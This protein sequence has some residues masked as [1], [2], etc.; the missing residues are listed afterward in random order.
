[1]VPALSSLT[2]LLA[3]LDRKARVLLSAGLI[4]VVAAA[5]S[6]GHLL[7]RN[8]NAPTLVSLNLKSGSREVALN[9]P[10]VF[11]FSRP[12]AES[13]VQAG[14]RI[15]P[16]AN[17]D[18]HQTGPVVYTWK[19]SDPW[20]DLTSYTVSMRAGEDESGHQITSRTWRFT[21]TIVPRVTGLLTTSGVSVADQGQIALGSGLQVTFNEALIQ[22]SVKLLVNQVPT[23]LTWAAD[24]KSAT[25]AGPSLHAGA[26]NF[27]LA[28][29]AHDGAGRPAAAWQLSAQVV[30][31]VTAHTLPLPY[32]AVIQVPNDA[33]AWDQSG[34]QSAS[35]VFQ[36]L[37]EGG[38]TRM[39]AIFSNVPDVV[40]PIRSGRL[41]SFQLTR[42]YGGRLFLSGLSGPEFGVLRAN[43]VPTWFESNGQMFRSGSRYAPDNLYIRGAQVEAVEKAQPVTASTIQKS[44]AI[45]ITSGQPASSFSVPEHNST[46]VYDPVTATYQKTDEG[47][48]MKDA[49]LGQPL[50]MQMVIVLHATETVEPHMVDVNGV[51]SLDFD[52]QTSGP[53]TF[54]Y[55]GLAAPGTWA[56]T[57][58]NQPLRFSLANGQA[59]PFPPGLVWVDV[60]AR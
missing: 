34:L 8:R 27:T 45:P 18:L 41:I 17:G 47:H 49:A 13:R 52:L 21:T 2:S 44:T 10:L 12:V 30:F 59:V 55:G 25:L 56:S 9:R 60:V 42:H 58:A 20:H 40:G 6:G 50:R 33:G 37:A 31:L 53:V 32:P 23:G 46:Y 36:Y 19:P 5:A 39:S 3:G 57:G 26:A 51:H 28:P 29:G 7:Y 54:Y 35:V 1:M 4:V 48:L 14:L 16:D 22:S 24:G 38:I 15:Q 11:T 43:P